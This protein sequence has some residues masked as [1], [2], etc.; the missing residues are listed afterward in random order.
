MPGAD[1]PEV[2]AGELKERVCELL[3]KDAE[4]T[5]PPSQGE[6][7]GPA[8][9]AERL[10]NLECLYLSDVVDEWNAAIRVVE[11]NCLDAYDI[12]VNRPEDNLLGL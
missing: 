1:G 5:E 6:E 4:E 7:N 3:K 9:R 2:Q 8:R 10:R 11:Q 12:F